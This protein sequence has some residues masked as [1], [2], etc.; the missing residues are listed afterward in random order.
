MVNR[1]RPKHDTAKSTNYN[2]WPSNII[3]LI[4]QATTQDSKEVECAWFNLIFARFFLELRESNYFLSKLIDKMTHKLQKLFKEKSGMIREFVIDEIDMGSN[5]ALF[6]NAKI[7]NDR[8]YENLNVCVDFS[9][10][11]GGGLKIVI[12][13]ELIGNLSIPIIVT[14]GAFVGKARLRVPSL[15]SAKKFDISFLSDPGIHFAID[16][17]LVHRD[18]ALFKDFLSGFIAR[19]LHNSFLEQWIFPS[20]RS[21]YLPL[22]SPSSSSDV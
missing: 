19:K 14:L 13:V 11:Y 6:S 10:E 5:S 20:Y 8:S 22:I 9:V 7:V 3:A 12:D 21:F 2:P 4:Q 18:N 15:S 16:A 1:K 17:A